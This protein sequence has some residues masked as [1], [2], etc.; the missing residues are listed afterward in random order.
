[1]K[2]VFG[3]PLTMS[4]SISFFKSRH[5]FLVGRPTGAPSPPGL[6]RWPPNAPLAKRTPAGPLGPDQRGDGQTTIRQ[7]ARQTA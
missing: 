5:L 6:S 3:I 2:R 7:S 1:M 4:E